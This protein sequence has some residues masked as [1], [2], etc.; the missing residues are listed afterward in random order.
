VPAER[1]I[2]VVGNCLV[3]PG[4]QSGSK[5]ERNSALK[6]V[7][8]DIAHLSLDGVETLAFAL[9][10]LDGQQLKKVTISVGGAGAGSFRAVE[11]SAR[12]VEA[13]CPRAGRGAGRSV[14]RSNSGCVYKSCCV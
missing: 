6:G 13:N 9:P 10:D 14:G 8:G 2:A 11:E 12:Y 4:A 5:R 1:D 7:A 3:R